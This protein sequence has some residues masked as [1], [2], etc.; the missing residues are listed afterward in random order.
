MTYKTIIDEKM[1]A[2]NKNPSIV[3]AGYE[4]TQL[5]SLYLLSLTENSAPRRNTEV[6]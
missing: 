6:K 5:N 2:L 3:S 4:K 1:I